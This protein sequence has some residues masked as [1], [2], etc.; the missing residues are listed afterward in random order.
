MGKIEIWTTREGCEEQA[1]SFNDDPEIN[2]KLGLGV[3]R[4]VKVAVVDPD[5]L[6]NG[7]VRWCDYREGE[8]SLEEVFRM[9]DVGYV[10]ACDKHTD[11]LILEN[12]GLLRL[13][14]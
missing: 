3:W 9:G 10:I 5:K 13:H 4:V 14:E 6:R 2:K 11:E 1:E 12:W 8:N 7:G